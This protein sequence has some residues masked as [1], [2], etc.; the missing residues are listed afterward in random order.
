IDPVGADDS[1]LRQTSLRFHQLAVR[2]PSDLRVNLSA[3]P[4]GQASL[5]PRPVDEF[6]K[7]WNAAGARPQQAFDLER[8]LALNAVLESLPAVPAVRASSTARFH[9]D[10]LDWTWSAEVTPAAA[11]Q[12]TYHL[13]VDPRLRIRS[14][15][16]R[17][18]DADR[19]LRWSPL[20]D[21]LVL[22]LNDR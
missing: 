14:V 9:P 20:R 19:L 2:Q 12:F 7:E 11:G 6:L 17:E 1:Q 21:T 4:T 15:S 5:R 3:A 18:D 13:H 22:F 10:H 8:N 16:V